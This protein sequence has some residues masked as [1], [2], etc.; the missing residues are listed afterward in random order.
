MGPASLKHY[1]L[2][3]KAAAV[4]LLIVSGLYCLNNTAADPDLWGYLAF[5]RLF[6]GQGP[7]PYEDV[8]AYV[9]TLKPWVYHEWLTGVF[10]YPLFR[11]LGAP[12]LQVLKFALGLATVGAVYLTARRRGADLWPTALLILLALSSLRMGYSPVR[13]QVFTYFGF[14]IFLYLLED[15]RLS[16]GW[17]KLWLLAPLE[18]VWCNLHGG[19]LAG[20]GL[21]F[22]YAVGAAL[23]RRP[24]RPYLVWF[25]L[26]GLAT[27]INPYGL[28]Y[29]SY[30]VQA[31]TMP[32]PEISEW[33]SIVEGYKQSFVG[34]YEFYYFLALMAVA[35]LLAGWARWRE[36]TPALV[37]VFTLYL[38][39]RHNRHQIFFTL[40]F[41]AYI[42]LLLSGYFREL[43]TR[44]GLMAAMDG[45]GRKIPAL[46][47]LLLIGFFAYRLA[48]HNP[49]RLE[50]PEEPSLA[51]RPA[52]YYPVGAL[53][54]LEQRHLGKKL[55]VHFD[56]GE[57]CLWRLYPQCLV[58]IDGRYETVYPEALHKEY[59]DFLMGRE[60]WRKF[61]ADYPPDLILIEL[62]SRVYGRLS[63]DPEWRQV[64]AD[65]GCA[66]FRRG[67]QVPPGPPAPRSPG[68]QLLP[69]GAGKG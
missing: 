47:V 42:P 52:P 66:L 28:R 69:P 51:I 61:L 58:A 21:I 4:L 27:L 31:V 25:L 8:F 3:L 12:G 30:L 32:R 22:L 16:G 10:F 55:L 19:F 67:G 63:G 56:W 7:F 14:A 50:I 17:G 46:A 68:A 6:W 13:A 41:V 43:S 54:Y 39:V 65:P 9:P 33:V 11:S 57:Y 64:Y 5:G 35:V 34:G 1:L 15:A 18:I 37:L 36:V 53:D 62:R 45:L 48:S 44:P 24:F 60:G 2:N 29:W 59:F 23:S 40:A 26:A 49:L 38:A 20:L